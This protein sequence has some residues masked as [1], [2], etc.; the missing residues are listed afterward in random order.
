LRKF[1]VRLEPV[2]DNIHHMYIKSMDVFRTVEASLTIQPVM[3][4]KKASTTSFGQ[5]LY[6]LRRARGFTQVRL[7]KA[8]GTTQRMISYYETEA[9]LPPSSVIVALTRIL[10]VSADELLGLKA[11]KLERQS[12][13][14]QRLW[15]RFRL[16]ESLRER[17]RRAVIRM[18]H[19]LSAARSSEARA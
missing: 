17:D 11:A 6:A 3:P 13:E 15:K 19:S 10:R 7:A 18:I 16:M 12:S 9:E 2:R 4:K 5:R 8:M 14:E 1:F